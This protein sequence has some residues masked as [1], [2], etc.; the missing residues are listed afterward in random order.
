[1]AWSAVDHPPP[2]ALPMR[3][4]GRHGLYIRS[5]FGPFPGCRGQCGSGKTATFFRLRDGEEAG[6]GKMAGD[7]S[8]TEQMW[9][10]WVKLGE[11]TP[12]KL[13]NMIS[14]MISVY[15]LSENPR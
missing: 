1:M 6:L 8:S 13:D 3:T 5:I 15:V 12:S 4:N 7:G 10:L 14:V 9:D 11:E 2:E